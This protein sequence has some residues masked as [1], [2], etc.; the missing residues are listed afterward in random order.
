MVKTF[1]SQL[2]HY[3]DQRNDAIVTTQQ[4]K[5]V[6]AQT[7]MPNP[8]GTM[9]DLIDYMNLQNYLVMKPNGRWRVNDSQARS[10]QPPGS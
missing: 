2:V 9:H 1:V 4:L 6:F 3:C 8:K 10:S 7:G 5:D